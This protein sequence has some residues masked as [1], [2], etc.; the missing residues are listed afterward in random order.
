MKLE[1]VI[2][3]APSKE[4]L[5]KLLKLF[6]N[7]QYNDVEKL[8]LVLTKK[9]PKHQ[10]AWKILGIT[11]QVAGRIEESLATMQKLI[12]LEPNNPETHN[13]LGISLHKLSR[14]YDAEKSFKQAIRFKPDLIEA[15]NNLGVTLQ[16]LGKL[17]EAENSY[18]QAI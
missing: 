6:H 13:N 3:L 8:A 5:S 16:E 4:Q 1:K 17:D 7:K 10:F 15:H 9:F 14:L 2:S 18:K 11:F 12:D